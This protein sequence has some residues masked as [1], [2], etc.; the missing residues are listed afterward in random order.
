[1]NHLQPNP[2]SNPEETSSTDYY[3]TEFVPMTNGGFAEN[4]NP[5]SYDVK[6]LGRSFDGLEV[7]CAI[8]PNETVCI[9]KGKFKGKTYVH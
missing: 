6:H 5:E 2:S 9:F 8:A 1:M 7:F 4:F 3:F